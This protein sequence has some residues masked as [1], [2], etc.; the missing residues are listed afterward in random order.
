[1]HKV[2]YKIL[3]LSDLDDKKQLKIAFK[4]FSW[5]SDVFDYSYYEVVYQ[6]SI[7]V[8]TT[9]IN[10]ILDILFAKFNVNQ[11]RDFVGRNLS[12]SDLIEIDGKTYYC[13]FHGWKDITNLIK[14]K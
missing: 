10:E 13:N 8:D 5:V 14:E 6:G 3:Q 11:P 7:E 4:D 2:E 1:M 12:V 9:N